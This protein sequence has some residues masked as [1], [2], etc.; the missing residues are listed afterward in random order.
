MTDGA[1]MRDV[2]HTHPFDD[3]S[4]GVLFLR[5]PTVVTDGGHDSGPPVDDARIANG[6]D[7]DAVVD[8]VTRATMRDVDHTPPHGEGANRVHERGEE[9]LVD[10]GPRTVRDESVEDDADSDDES[11]NQS[12]DA[13]RS[14]DGN[15]S[16]DGNRTTDGNR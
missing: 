8:E 3:R 6:E 10:H 16:P 2:D 9:R 5:G 1:T 15:R 7:P 12:P 13:D 11:G 4:A 14:T